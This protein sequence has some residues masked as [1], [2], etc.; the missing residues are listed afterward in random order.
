MDRPQIFPLENGT[1]IRT[2]IEN[3]AV[4]DWGEGAR[5]HCQWGVEGT[6]ITHHD[7]HGDC[8]EVRHDDG[9]IAAYDP[10]EVTEV[11]E[12]SI[13]KNKDYPADAGQCDDCGGDGCTTCEDKGWLPHGHPK[14]RLCYR[15]KCDNPS[16]PGQVAVYCSNNCA[17][18]DA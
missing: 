9:T 10:S 16:P 12:S 8:Y 13:P 18:A 3:D 5:D 2:T 7:S 14:I 17:A 4:T 1:R 6:I 11:F 15:E